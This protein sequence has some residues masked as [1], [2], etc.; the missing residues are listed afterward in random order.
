MTNRS[1]SAK[2]L[3]VALAALL[4]G[5]VAVLIRETYFAPRH[6]TAHFTSATSIY[7]GDEVRVAGVKVGTIESI[8]PAGDQAVF[9][10]TVDRDV[11]VPA[12]A[13]AII[14]A[15][16]LISA[17]YVQLTPAYENSGPVLADDAVIGVERTAVPVE[18][19]EVKQQLTRL[20]TEL[21]PS[22]D[23]ST[24]SVGRFI[25][26]AANAMDGN[27]Q[28]LRETIAQLSGV[29]RI[30][31]DGSG[32]IVAVIKNLQIFVTALRDSNVQIVQF[33]D[34]L[35][36][37]SSVV[38]GGR[39]DMDAA[40]TNLAEAVGEVRRFVEGSRDQTA[41]QL[42]RLANITQNL[43][44]NKT[45]LENVL[46]VAPNA[47]GNGYNIYNPDT[48]TM[49]GGFAM[50]NFAN[51]V[52]LV[53]SAIGAVRNATAAETAKI[54]AEY[55]GPA[56]R[57]LNFNYLPMPFNAYLKKAPSPGNLIYSDPSVAPGGTGGS[58]DQV[59]TPPAVSAYTGA[60][61]VAPPP[62]WATPPG[63]PGAYAPNGLPAGPTPA[64][65]PGAP[66]PP[67]PPIAG[68]PA[69]TSVTDLLLPAETPPAP[70][71]P[72]LEGNP[73]S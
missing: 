10:L 27:G 33:Q 39:A 9:R 57:L 8:T 4:V 18:W 37:V 15:Q 68:P 48:G 50:G 35:A 19:D 6:I 2:V 46:H 55:L 12:D 51:P 11:P 40:L 29:G 24:T 43:V 71:A 67:G 32:D 63:P 23:V 66:I 22:S 17:R 7:P 72:P 25:D 36:T 28:K 34:R 61:D 42:Q 62:G 16:N 52:Q 47:I 5:G 60:G 54:C 49:I 31:S 58:A 70:A 26:S 69:P 13:K 38:D 41:E 14:V 59:E 45:D 1:R 73:P 65:F 56:L 21:G 20:A 44:D 53:C 30:L 3:A 64:L